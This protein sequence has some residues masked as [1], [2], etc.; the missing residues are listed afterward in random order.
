MVS[1]AIEAVKK[2]IQDKLMIVIA[3]PTA[4]G[5]TGS[6]IE[7]AKYLDIE[8]ISA[9]SRQI[10]KYMDI[11][12]A[13]AT[14]EEQSAVKHHFI[15]IIEPDELYSAGR[16]G[17]EASLVAEDILKRNKIPC[18]VGGSGLYIKA[19]AEG[20]FDE[21]KNQELL[22]IRERLNAEYQEDGID[23]MFG[24]LVAVDPK[25][26]QLYSDRNP[27]R[28]IRALEY[29]ELHKM[30]ISEAH[31]KQVIN[32]NFNPMYFAIDFD[33]E[34][35]YDRINSRAEIMWKNGLLEETK[36]ILEMGYLRDLNPLNSPGYK[37]AI[38]F[39]ESEL[40]EEEALDKMKMMTR[41][42]AKRQFTW[43]KKIGGICW[44]RGTNQEI[45]GEIVRKMKER[46]EDYS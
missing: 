5:K 29:Y 28:I 27:R 7:L 9:D 2:M 14:E 13:K 37:E 8:V 18:V 44:L 25:S 16:F 34:G 41:R 1:I 35:L 32:R 20:L 12:T 11:G 24:R 33:R 3:G 36:Q 43:F 22:Q 19:L 4:S 40:S 21:E 31:E 26:A 30:P 17:D 38:E 46:Y 39:F 6:S 23:P 45:A 10:Y 15:D 42:Y